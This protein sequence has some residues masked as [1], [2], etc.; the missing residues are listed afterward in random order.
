[1]AGAVALVGGVGLI[2]VRQE[3]AGVAPLD[4]PVT[5][6]VVVHVEPASARAVETG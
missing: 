4:V 5:L 6:A 2:V 1:L 3:S